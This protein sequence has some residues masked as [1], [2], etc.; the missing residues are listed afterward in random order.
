M[1]AGHTPPRDES[2]FEDVLKALEQALEDNRHLRDL[3]VEEVARQLILGG[4]LQDKPPFLLVE[5]ALGVIK[6]EEQAFGP[7][8]PPEEA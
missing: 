7:D 3:P 1:S 4:Y 2:D 6:A 5:E 8:I